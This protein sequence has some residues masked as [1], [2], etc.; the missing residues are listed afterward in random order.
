MTIFSEVPA[1]P[2]A[3]LASAVTEPGDTHRAGRCGEASA[4]VPRRPA[5][6]D[7]LRSNRGSVAVELAII[8][9]LILLIMIGFGEMYLYMRAVSSVEHTAFTLADSISQMTEVI[10]DSTT[11]NPNNLG[12]I[13]SAAALLAAPSTLEAGGG[14][15]VTSICD[16]TTTPCGTAAAT[17]GS[18]VAGTPEIYWQE[19]AT[20]TGSGMTTQET[21]T[22]MLPTTWPFRNGDSAIVVEVFYTFTPFSLVKGLW[23]A[24]PGTQTIYRRVYVRPRNGVALPLVSS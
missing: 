15:I 21:S 10:D 24:A 6:R 9:P 4:N 8:V 2:A 17:S 16:K 19:S 13:W 7:L 18:M 3:P 22:S 12:S 20:W 23:A 11:T 1:P 14:V 5:L